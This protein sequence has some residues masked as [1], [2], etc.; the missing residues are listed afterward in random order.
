MKLVNVDANDQLAE[1]IL[2]LDVISFV[3]D[4]LRPLE[5]DLYDYRKRYSIIPGLHHPGNLP[6]SPIRKFYYYGYENA[7]NLV[8]TIPIYLRDH[9]PEYINETDIVDLLGAYY[10]NRSQDNPYIELFLSNIDSASNGDDKHFKY[11]LT[12]VLIHEIAHAALDIFN[13]EHCNS[14]VEKVSYCTEFGKWR[15][16]SMANAVALHIIKDYGNQDFYDYTKQFMLRQPKEYALG[17]QM[18][19]FGYWDFESVVDCKEHGAYAGL[20]QEWLKY[21]QGNPSW[22]GLK[23]WN[24]ILTSTLDAN[25]LIMVKDPD[26][27]KYGM[28]DENYVVHIPFDYDGISSTSSNIY[29][30]TRNNQYAILDCDNKPIVPFGRYDIIIYDSK[31]HN[32]IVSKNG[33][34]GMLDTDARPW[35]SLDY[36]RIDEE[37]GDLRWIKKSSKFALVDRR[38]HEV[39]PSATYEDVDRYVDGH[40]PVKQNGKWGIIDRSGKIIVPCEY[41]RIMLYNGGAARMFKEDVETTI[42]LK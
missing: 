2:H 21:A 9:R 39:V 35:I 31:S 27:D 22:K 23:L 26:S 16:E 19:D 13:R 11:L 7:A 34:V 33:K 3:L 5:R 30:V 6:L 4:V 42:N 28:V 10:P 20:Q 40:A 41:D 25:K 17:V 24:E 1:K 37:C 38:F 12:K 14:V 29:L 32:F 15:E 8:H 36:D 18:E